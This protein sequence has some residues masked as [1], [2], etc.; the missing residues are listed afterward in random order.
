MNSMRQRFLLYFE[1]VRFPVQPNFDV[2]SDSSTTTT[3][4]SGK[5]Q[6]KKIKILFGAFP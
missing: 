3:R 6:K 2:G 4:R 1:F 5:K